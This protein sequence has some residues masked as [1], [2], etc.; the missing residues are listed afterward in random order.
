MGTV[1][2]PI[3][4]GAYINLQV[5]YGLI[6]LVNTKADLCEQTKQA[7]LECP[8]EKGKLTVVKDVEIPKEVPPVC[9]PNRLNM[10]VCSDSVANNT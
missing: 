9:F 10:L 6:R 2:E 3:L 4:E 1:K 7:D 8:I 5:K